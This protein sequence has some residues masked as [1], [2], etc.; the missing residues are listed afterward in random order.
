MIRET[1]VVAIMEMLELNV[2]VVSNFFFVA[3]L[4]HL[5]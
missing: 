4:S 5:I 1:D 2:N 3:T